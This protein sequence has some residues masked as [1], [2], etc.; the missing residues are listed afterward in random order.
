MYGHMWMQLPPSPRPRRPLVPRP[1]LRETVGLPPPVVKIL[2][3]WYYLIEGYLSG[4]V[5]V[6]EGEG[7]V[8]WQRLRWV[9]HWVGKEERKG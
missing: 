3:V 2:L 5:M 7:V 1:P 8:S 6:H 9:M 4:C